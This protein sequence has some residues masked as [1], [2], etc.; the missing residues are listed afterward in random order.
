VLTPT[1]PLLPDTLL[2]G[3]DRFGSFRADVARRGRA[4]TADFIFS[5]VVGD[6]T[7]L[8]HRAYAEAAFNPKTTPIAGLATSEAEV[9]QMGAGIAAGHFSSAPH[10]QSSRRPPTRDAW[11]ACASA[12]ARRPGGDAKPT[13]LVAARERARSEDA[14][15]LRRARQ[16]RRPANGR[17]AAVSAGRRRPIRSCR[18]SRFPDA[19]E[20]AFVDRVRRSLSGGDFLLIIAGDGI[21]YGAE[22]PVAFL[23]RFGHLRFG[24]ALV[25]VAAYKLPDG[26]TLLQPRVLAK[27]ELLQRT[28]L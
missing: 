1:Y 7:A 2:D 6:S 12:M 14:C 24:L 10:F 5:T 4:E 27:P 8:P 19:D 21:R 9:R 22:S 23:E 17:R 3:A 11:S 25:E 13:A 20:V 18:R 28:L 15:A 16:L 26:S